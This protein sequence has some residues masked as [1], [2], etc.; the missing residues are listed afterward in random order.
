MDLAH[1]KYHE[2]RN[3]M[4]NLLSYIH[5][6]SKKNNFGVRVANF[7]QIEP[8]FYRGGLPDTTGWRDL[9]QKLGVRHVYNLIGSLEPVPGSVLSK[10][11]Q[12]ALDAGIVDFAHAPM[13]D[14]ATPNIEHIKDFLMYVQ[15]QAFR[16]IFIG[17][18]GNRHRGS[19]VSAVYCVV[20]KGQTKERAWKEQAE[21]YGYY[22]RILISRDHSPLR[23]WFEN[24]FDPRD[25]R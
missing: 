8:G 19:L 5:T 13:Q 18:A 24:E 22:D 15:V 12:E 7:G 14:D 21:A 2:E 1:R 9:V 16:P 23:L 25:F 11:E 6:K 17:C 10:P 4:K 20:V 3:T